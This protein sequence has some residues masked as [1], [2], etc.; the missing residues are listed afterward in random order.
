[1]VKSC[2]NF[3]QNLFYPASVYP[4]VGV[5]NPACTSDM[6]YGSIWLCFYKDMDVILK[7]EERNFENSFNSMIIRD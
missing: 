7:T 5:S 4:Q 1:M 2:F 6:E 3:V